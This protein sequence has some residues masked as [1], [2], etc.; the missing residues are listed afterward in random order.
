MAPSQ[1]LILFVRTTRS[2]VPTIEPPR[3]QSSLAAPSSHISRATRDLFEAAGHHP[4]GPS[5]QDKIAGCE[6]EKESIAAAI[7]LPILF[8]HLEETGYASK[9]MLLHGPPG[10][11]KTKIATAVAA[12][13]PGCKVYKVS[14]SSLVDKYVGSSE[15]N[16]KALFTVAQ[17]NSPAVIIMD[18]IDAL[19]GIRESQSQSEGAIQRMKSELLEAMSTYSVIVVGL[20]NL[21]WKIDNA[22]IRRFRQLFHIGLP[23]PKQCAAILRLK[24]DRILHEINAQE[25]HYLAELCEGFS[26]DL[27]EN[28]VGNVWRES[29]QR[30]E[31]A[32]HF[33]KV[34]FKD[35]EIYCPC[36]VEHKES[37]SLNLSDIANRLYPEHLTFAA[38]EAAL[39]HTQRMVPLLSVQANKHIK[40]AREPFQEL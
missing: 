30:M 23:D 35:K 37:E 22:F 7:R 13:I 18:E 6:E 25:V 21:P 10:T 38:L 15:R 3:L 26:G 5:E 9:G 1:W 16:V 2:E 39:R 17:E 8:P 31:K 24:L 34:I 32:T 29:F 12:S 4:A 19:F 27:I 14:S 36:S 33:R 20:T 11:G 28:A 40:W